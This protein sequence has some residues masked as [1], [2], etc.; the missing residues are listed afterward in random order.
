MKKTLLFS[1]ALSA[2]FALSSCKSQES[3]YRQAYNKAREQDA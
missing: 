1:F 2:V 3:A